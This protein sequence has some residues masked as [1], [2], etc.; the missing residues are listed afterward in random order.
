M[1]SKM[2]SGRIISFISY[3]K[4]FSTYIKYLRIS[5]NVE[6]EKQRC[7]QT[8]YHENNATKS[9][10]YFAKFQHFKVLASFLSEIFC[11]IA[12]DLIH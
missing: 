12:E 10:E 1:Y 8:F 11:I 7:I 5:Q 4:L 2:V 9:R 3:F 6:A